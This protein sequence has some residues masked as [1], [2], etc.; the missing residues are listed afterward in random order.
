MIKMTVDSAVAQQSHQVQISVGF[1]GF[2]DCFQYSFIFKKTA[3]LDGKINARQILVEH[4][5]GSNSGVSDFGIAHF[6]PTQTHR[7]SRGLQQGVGAEFHQ[8]VVIRGLGVKNS[9]TLS[10]GIDSPTVEDY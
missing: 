5:T 7:D 10:F 2:I 4:F 8:P 9:V 1:F 3:V 6:I